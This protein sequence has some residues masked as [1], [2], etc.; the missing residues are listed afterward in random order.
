MRNDM[1]EN[2]DKDAFSNIKIASDYPP[3]L[4]LGK[5]S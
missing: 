1:D 5:I 2:F 3:K 4:T